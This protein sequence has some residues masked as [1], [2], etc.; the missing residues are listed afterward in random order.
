MSAPY[1]KGYKIT[2][3]GGEEIFTPCPAVAREWRS[4][5]SAKVEEVAM[6][7]PEHDPDGCK[8]CIRYMW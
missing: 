8:D 5:P 1:R 4:S 2:P 3:Q 6:D 7:G